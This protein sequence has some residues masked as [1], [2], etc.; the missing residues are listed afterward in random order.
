MINERSS[1]RSNMPIYPTASVAD[2]GFKRQIPR[3]DPSNV[4]SP[5]ISLFHSRYR[6][7]EK[8][9]GVKRE[10][11]SNGPSKVTSR[12]I[13]LASI[14]DIIFYSIDELALFD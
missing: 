1:K 4:T 12:P 2:V 14:A 11:T 7:E 13:P 6:S 3:K 5:P 8:D 9:I 10:V